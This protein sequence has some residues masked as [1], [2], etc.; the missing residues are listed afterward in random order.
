MWNISTKCGTVP[1]CLGLLGYCSIQIRR[2]KPNHQQKLCSTL[3]RLRCN[4]QSRYSR[5]NAGAFM[6]IQ[7]KTRR[8]SRLNLPKS[9]TQPRI[10]NDQNFHSGIKIVKTLNYIGTE[11]LPHSFSQCLFRELT[12]WV[13]RLRA[14]QDTFR[15]GRKPE[16]TGFV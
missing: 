4:N 3:S 12:C 2:E 15:F 11:T 14:Y 1:L 6:T 9:I 10:G 5:I 7:H 13:T 16:I 8:K